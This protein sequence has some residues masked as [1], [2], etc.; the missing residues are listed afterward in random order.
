MTDH[1]VTMLFKKSIR[2]SVALVSSILLPALLLSAS[3][4]TGKRSVASEPTDAASPSSIEEAWGIRIVALR[5]AAEGHMLDFR[6]QVTDP[7]KA[8]SLL[9][10]K[11]HPYV[12]DEA[13]GTRL[14]VPSAPKVGSLRQKTEMP[15]TGKVYFILFSNAAKF[16]KRG[17]TV[18]VVV[19][20]FK[21]ENI[22]VE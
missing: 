5:L 19:G 6:Y 18:T 11:I 12:I 13:S 10:R 21:A 17:N 15:E 16:V 7:D 1:L 3:C 2:C 22:V 4:A 8:R 14:T 9:A 20:D